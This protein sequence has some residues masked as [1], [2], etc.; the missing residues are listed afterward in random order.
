ML[1]LPAGQLTQVLFRLGVVCVVALK[2]KIK[3]IQ[4]K[5]T[6]KNVRTIFPVLPKTD[7]DEN[8]FRYFFNA[9]FLQVLD[10]L[11]FVLSLLVRI[12]IT[13]LGFGSGYELVE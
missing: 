3:Q 12:Q 2:P 5:Q 1:L 9:I 7:P 13:V 6:I 11:N 4:S 10:I 8:I